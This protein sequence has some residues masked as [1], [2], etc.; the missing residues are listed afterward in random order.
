LADGYTTIRVM[1]DTREKL[2]IFEG[3]LMMKGKRSY[4]T[5]EVID[6]LFR[7]ADTTKLEQLPSSYAAEGLFEK[8]KIYSFTH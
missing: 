6:Q 1:N 2:R 7:I 5:D 4:T 3:F 8:L